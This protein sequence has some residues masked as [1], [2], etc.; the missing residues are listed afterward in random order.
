MRIALRLMRIDLCLT[1]F[2]LITLSQ[3]LNSLSKFFPQE[4]E[5]RLRVY[6]QDFLTKEGS[7]S[8][9]R[10]RGGKRVP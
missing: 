3:R 5:E 9:F 10:P 1:S 8:A 7:W 6:T 4:A 2:F